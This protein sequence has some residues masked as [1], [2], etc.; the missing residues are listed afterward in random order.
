MQTINHIALASVSV[1]F[2]FGLLLLIAYMTYKD[3]QDE[4]LKNK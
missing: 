3:A 1:I 2:L 4:D